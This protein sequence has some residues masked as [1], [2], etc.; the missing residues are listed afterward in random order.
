MKVTLLQ[1]TP[2]PDETVALAA[3]TC[4]S[5]GT[6][7]ALQAK[8]QP[9]ARRREFLHS[10]VRRGHLTPLEHASFTFS[11]EGISRA[12]SH[13]MVRHRIASFCQRS[14]RYVEVRDADADW[15]VV[16][17]SVRAQPDAEELYRRHLDRLQDLYRQ[18]LNLGVPKEDARYL[19]PNATTTAL[20]A[21]LNA[22]ALLH[23]LSLR[24]CGR[25]QW[26]IRAVAAAMLAAARRVAPDLLAQAGPACAAGDCPEGDHGCG[27]GAESAPV[28]AVA[29]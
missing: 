17:P 1:H 5:S 27:R 16:P 3:R 7:G 22:R 10:L 21:T 28:A 13:Q 12:C 26:E 14:Q 19:L 9:P 25:A 20:V 4:Y 29:G 23:F 11:I 8:P 2:S 15:F 18:L 6:I 24:L